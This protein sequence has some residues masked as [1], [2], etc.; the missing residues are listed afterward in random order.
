MQNRAEYPGE[1]TVLWRI[2]LA[3]A[4]AQGEF[5]QGMIRE[6]KFL[7]GVLLGG[8]SR[9]GLEEILC[10]Q[11]ERMERKIGGRRCRAEREA[12]WAMEL[13]ERGELVEIADAIGSGRIGQ[14]LECAVLWLLYGEK[15]AGLF[16]SVHG[17]REKRKMYLVM[18]TLAE[19]GNEIDADILCAVRKALGESFSWA[20]LA[21]MAFVAGRAGLAEEFFAIGKESE[22]RREARQIR[23]NKEI[24]QIRRNRKGVG[25]IRRGDEIRKTRRNRERV[26]KRRRNKNK[27]IRQTR[28]NRNKRIG[29]TRRGSR[30][31]DMKQIRR[32]NRNKDTRQTRRGNRNKDMKQTRRDNRNKDMK[33]TRRDNRNKEIRQT[34][35]GN[36]NKDMKQIRRDNRNKE[37]KQTRRNKEMKQ[38]R[39]GNRNK[40][41]TQAGGN[42]NKGVGQTRRNKGIRISKEMERLEKTKEKRAPDRETRK[43]NTERHSPENEKTKRRNKKREKAARM[44]QE[45]LNEYQK[46]TSGKY[47]KQKGLNKKKLVEN[48]QNRID[49]YKKEVSRDLAEK[50]EQWDQEPPSQKQSPK[51]EKNNYIKM[52]E[53]A[54]K[55]CEKER[56]NKREPPENTHRHR[57]KHRHRNKKPWGH[58]RKEEEHFPG[59]RR[60]TDT[61]SGIGRT[62]GK[63]TEILGP[64]IDIKA[65]PPR[66]SIS[67]ECPARGRF[68]VHE[69]G[70]FTKGLEGDPD[71]EYSARPARVA[72]SE[73]ENGRLVNIVG[74]PSSVAA[75]AKGGARVPGRGGTV[76][77]GPGVVLSNPNTGPSLVTAPNG[78]LRRP[79]LVPRVVYAEK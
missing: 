32:D 35:R 14:R 12:E 7:S 24:R 28:R 43:T 27:E 48:L 4:Y 78:E 47:L 46:K 11:L 74:Y 2:N 6:K 15:S 68:V 39:R 5:L 55:N 63:P 59:T 22:A 65:P 29:Q 62:G 1:G 19:M 45:A 51:K 70:V 38:T 37:M 34:R 77:I 18:D 42:R 31:K 58:R 21:K 44:M 53:K 64:V 20:G 16:Q 61:F 73:T 36:R 54:L 9:R 10:R 40:E 25:Q 75:V 13:M 72:V 76:E 71:Y 23:R 67:I 79:F 60:E 69:S 8:N 41:M 52:L 3:E 66:R 56:E 57:R 50:R 30:S 33:Q 26:G 17:W 49:E